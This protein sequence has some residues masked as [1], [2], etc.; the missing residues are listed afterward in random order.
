M[1]RSKRTRY[2]ITDEARAEFARL[3]KTPSA[4]ALAALRAPARR[5]NTDPRRAP[6]STQRRN[7]LRDAS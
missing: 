3:P 7:A 6:R 2:E 1:A 5:A 4:V